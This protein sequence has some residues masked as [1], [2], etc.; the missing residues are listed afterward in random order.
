MTGPRGFVA[1]SPRRR[2]TNAQLCRMIGRLAHLMCHTR[3]VS[4]SIFLIQIPARAT[5]SP[6]THVL[7]TAQFK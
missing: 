6:S 3:H 5:I 7:E 4:P 1:E 2:G